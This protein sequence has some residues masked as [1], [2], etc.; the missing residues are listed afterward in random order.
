MGVD[1]IAFEVWQKEHWGLGCGLGHGGGAL[2]FV[3][4]ML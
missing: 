3:V 4:K 1:D 2:G